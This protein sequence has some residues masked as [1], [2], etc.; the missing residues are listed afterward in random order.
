MITLEHVSYSIPYQFIGQR[1]DVKLTDNKVSVYLHCELIAEHQHIA[2]GGSILHEHMPR[3][4]QLQDEMQPDK[5]LSWAQ[6]IG[7]QTAHMV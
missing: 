7:K 6:N 1:V 2:T 5:L 4:H 3:N